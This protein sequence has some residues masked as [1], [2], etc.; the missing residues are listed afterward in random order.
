MAFIFDRKTKDATIRRLLQEVRKHKGH[1]HRHQNHNSGAPASS[2]SPSPMVPP[3]LVRA[4]SPPST[5]SF[6][7]APSRSPINQVSPDHRHSSA[8]N[9]LPSVQVSPP[10]GKHDSHWI[11]FMSVAAGSCFLLALSLVYFL[12]CRANKVVTVMPWRTGLSGQLQK[13]FVTGWFPFQLFKASCIL[14]SI[15]IQ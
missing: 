3:P 4:N 6:P 13:A 11:V 5:N 1:H 10:P 14:I 8:A 15:F 12:C 9:S 7:P 2:P